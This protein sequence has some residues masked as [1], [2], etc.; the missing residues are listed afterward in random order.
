M[1]T[2]NIEMDTFLETYNLP[3][4][5]QKKQIIRTDE[6]IVLKMNKQQFKNL[7][8]NNCSGLDGFTGEFYQTFKKQLRIPW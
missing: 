3:G 5:N 4:L 7:P 6:L 2:D 8:P 1:P